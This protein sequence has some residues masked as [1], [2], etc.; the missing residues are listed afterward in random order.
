S[1]REWVHQL[2]QRPALLQRAARCIFTT[3]LRVARPSVGQPAY[4]DFQTSVVD[5][6]GRAHSGVNSPST[7]STGVSVAPSFWVGALSPPTAGSLPGV[8]ANS[9]CFCFG[10]P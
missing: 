9:G 10:W 7:G 2:L 6:W 5:P 3:L 8:L 4:S 1:Y